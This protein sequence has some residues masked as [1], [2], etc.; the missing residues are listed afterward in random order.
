MRN[1]LYELVGEVVFRM[2]GLCVEK[3]ARAVLQQPETERQTTSESDVFSDASVLHS[4]HNGFWISTA[5]FPVG[6]SIQ[7]EY[8]LQD[9]KYMGTV[10]VHN[11]TEQ[12]V[13]TEP[14]LTQVRLRV[15]GKLQP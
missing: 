9:W 6:T 3:N 11:T 13:Q 4:E 5:T 7:Y 2:A 10:E 1:M 8:W 12:F 14:E 15:V